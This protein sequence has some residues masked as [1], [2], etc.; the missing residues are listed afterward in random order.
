MDFARGEKAG[1]CAERFKAGWHSFVL[2]L[3]FRDGFP[4][5]LA[6]FYASRAPT[7][8]RALIRAGVGKPRPL[9]ISVY[10][11]RSEMNSGRFAIQSAETEKKPRNATR[12][13]CLGASERGHP[14]L[15]YLA[16][17]RA[18]DLHAR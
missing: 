9:A 16:R 15:A 18:A 12:G 2:I 7:R 13:H 5:A 1:S 14:L 6:L 10:L 8:A 11:Y 3:R 17:Y 4:K